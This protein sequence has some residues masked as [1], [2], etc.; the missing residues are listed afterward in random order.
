MKIS[1]ENMEP[2]MRLDSNIAHKVALCVVI[3]IASNMHG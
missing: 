3:L 2:V 1:L